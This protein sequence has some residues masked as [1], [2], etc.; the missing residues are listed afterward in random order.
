MS[1][2]IKFALDKIYCASK[3]DEQ[4]TF[5]L[6]RVNLPG[7]SLINNVTIYNIVKRLPSRNYRYHV[8]TIGAVDPGLLNLLR[9]GK[10]WYRDVWV[11]VSD[12]MVERNYIFQLYN[13]KGVM[14]P[15]DKIHYSFIDQNSL[16]IA[17]E[18]DQSLK[19]TFDIVSF[20][21]LHV[22]SNSYFNSTEYSLLTKKLGI[23]YEL[24]YAFDNTDKV[25]LQNKIA[26]W[27]QN[28]GRT[29]IYV[30]GYH[31][32]TLNLNIPNMSY[33]EI[34]YD[35]SIISKEVFNIS[36]LRTFSSILDDKNKYLLFRNNLINRIQF[37]DDN[38][39]YIS[40][41]GELV[42]KGLFFYQHK[43]YAVRNVSDK[44]YSLSS[45]FINTIAQNVSDLTSGTSQDKVIILYTRQTGLQ[46]ELIYSNLK[47]NELY[48]LPQN[49]ELDVL[50]SN[51]Y[52][53]PDLRVET[54]ENSDY[55]KIASNK[56]IR[57][58]T[59]DLAVS[60]LGYSGITYYFANTP[61]YVNDRVN[62]DV[63]L[64]YQE[65]STAFEYDQNGVYLDNYDTTGLVYTVKNP[66][67]RHIEY[68]YGRTPTNYPEL[69]EPNSIIEL[70]HTEYK[71]LSAFFVGVTN[72]TGWEDI[73]TD[74][75][76]RTINNNIL[77][78]SER[79]GYKVKIVYFNQPLIYDLELSIADGSLYFPLTI[80]EDR[81]TGIQSFPLDLPYRNIELFL[82]G[83]RLVYGLDY[84]IDFPNVNIC[85]KTYLNYASVTQ[86]VH[87]RAYGF[88]LDTN[89]IN[90][91]EKVGY[92]NNGTV[93]RNNQYD[94]TEDRVLSIYVGG[95]LQNRNN[96]KVAEEDQ[97][98]RISDGNN[99]KPY[100]IKEGLIPIKSIANVET[101]PIYQ[102]NNEKNKRITELFNQVFPEPKINEFNVISQRHQ[103]FS[104]LISKLLMDI[105]DGNI[106]SSVYES[107]YNDSTI[108]NLLAE[109]QY[110]KLLKTDPVK[111]DLPQGLV[112]LHPHLGNSVIN[113]N[114][115][116]Y[117]FITNVIRIIT[118]NT[119]NK[120]NLSGY[121]RL[122]A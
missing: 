111:L 65:K 107:P 78:L 62:V 113:V 79:E 117:R 101:L 42:N 80:K 100:S 115:Y 5:K 63:P 33:I 98:V 12:D 19:E 52:L 84:Q 30:N 21:Y 90:Q 4:Y 46:R 1:E 106:S 38:E 120:I 57:N 27:E 36:D 61:N 96:I 102:A 116:V 39:I 92:V 28:G 26:T 83:Y 105:I 93:L 50:S 64:L 110:A 15:R 60:A 95:Q 11:K 85:N 73:T 69:Y 43:N 104:P 122:T 118:L 86:K 54:L 97:T 53:S 25:A 112:D 31:T 51:G 6:V 81:G 70:Q 68:L 8:F 94:I 58:I 10:D 7:Q 76:K 89:D 13:S 49:V 22:Y 29:L 75:S 121:L 82:N 77:T 16:L 88:T 24:T 59:N 119:P 66:N 2:I 56:K 71:I 9:Q 74:T 32:D 17:L 44:D 114:L 23:E 40:N 91:L 48:K 103:L 67:A 72:V 108:L 20:Q 34:V 14:Y 3:Q 87:V 99:G 109:P 41:K 47:L 45:E 18:F 35:Q 55:F 37:K